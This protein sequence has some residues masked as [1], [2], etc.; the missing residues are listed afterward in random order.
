MSNKNLPV[1]LIVGQLLTFSLAQAEEND[2]GLGVDVFYTKHSQK[3]NVTGGV[4]NDFI[5]LDT[6]NSYNSDMDGLYA[7]SLPALSAPLIG[8]MSRTVTSVPIIRPNTI[9]S[10]MRK[11]QRAGNGF[12]LNSVSDLITL[13][14]GEKDRNKVFFSSFFTSSVTPVLYNTGKDGIDAV[15]NAFASDY[16]SFQVQ[17]LVELMQHY[18]TSDELDQAV[19]FGGGLYSSLLVSSASKFNIELSAFLTPEDGSE[20]TTGEGFSDKAYEKLRQQVEAK[21]RSNIENNILVVREIL[22]RVIFDE[23]Y[24]PT[25]LVAF[26]GKSKHQ[27]FTLSKS[28]G[29]L[30]ISYLIGHKAPTPLLMMDVKLDTLDRDELSFAIAYMMNNLESP[31]EGHRVPVFEGVWVVQ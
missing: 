11:S 31:K 4:G 16:P 9:V 30:V 5:Y 25:Y 10:D 24:E 7:V 3:E 21:D 29:K 20:M 27:F 15:L 26:S 17:N 1:L 18:K 28:E 22:E 2:N 6:V 19:T 14:G 23:R 8:E 13:F 12:V